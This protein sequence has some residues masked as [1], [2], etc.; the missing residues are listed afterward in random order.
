MIT[1]V[2]ELIDALSRFPRD[3]EIELDTGADW[4]TVSP[5]TSVELVDRTVVISSAEQ[6]DDD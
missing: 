5:V 4:Q 6:N 3:A 2:G 1:N